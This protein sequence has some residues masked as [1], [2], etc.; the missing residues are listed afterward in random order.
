MTNSCFILESY[1]YEVN[2]KYL[3][4]WQEGLILDNKAFQVKHRPHYSKYEN[5]RLPIESVQL[6]D[7]TWLR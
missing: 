2:S 3:A 5:S 7:N 1:S 4:S 6:T